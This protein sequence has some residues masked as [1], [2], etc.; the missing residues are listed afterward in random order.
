M[1]TGISKRQIHCQNFIN[2]DLTFLQPSV[3]H[4]SQPKED[5]ILPEAIT[6]EIPT[7]THKDNNLHQELNPNSS[8]VLS[9]EVFY[10]RDRVT[11]EQLPSSQLNQ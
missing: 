10:N 9:V 7:I 4:V 6:T 11:I 3:I 2:Q 8:P 5:S 1:I